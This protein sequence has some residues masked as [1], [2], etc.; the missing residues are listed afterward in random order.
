MW[1]IVK[2]I[3]TQFENK[4]TSLINT[5]EG[6]QEDT[7]K[8]NEQ[9]SSSSKST[10]PL[11]RFNRIMERDD[12]EESSASLEESTSSCN[13]HEMLK[14]DSRCCMANTND[15][16]ENV[17]HASFKNLSKPDISLLIMICWYLWVGRNNKVWRNISTTAVQTIER[18]SSYLRDW[19]EI[20]DSEQP[21]RAHADIFEINWRKPQPGWVKLNVDAAIDVNGGRMGFR[22][23]LRDDIGEFKAGRCTPWQGTYTPKEAEAVA[24]REAL[25]WLKSNH[26]DYIMLETDALTVAQSLNST[27]GTSSFDLIVLDIKD[28]L[29]WFSHVSI[30]FVK[31]SAGCPFSCSGVPF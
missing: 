10:T 2:P 18:A 14:V 20:T 25:S 4:C 22:W 19:K 28:R 8:G 23:I 29:S 26:L 27:L 16:E 5:K 7:V 30:S 1:D 9:C 11:E 6:D 31:R 13:I 12:T 24:I 17:T 3:P 15:D 21:S